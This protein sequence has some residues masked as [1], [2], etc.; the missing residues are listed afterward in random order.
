MERAPRR[1]VNSI[2]MF[3]CVCVV[4]VV[5]LHKRRR[6]CRDILLVDGSAGVL[7]N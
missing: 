2:Y 6:S 3:V 1:L 5:V 4:V 7:L